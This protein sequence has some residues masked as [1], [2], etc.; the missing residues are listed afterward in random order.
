MTPPREYQGHPD[1]GA[2]PQNGPDRPD[3]SYQDRPWRAIYLRL[4]EAA[5]DTVLDHAR[6]YNLRD[7]SEFF[8]ASLRRLA[9]ELTIYDPDLF[10]RELGSY[11]AGR[12]MGLDARGFYQN[13]PRPIGRAKVTLDPAPLGPKTVFQPASYRKEAREIV[14]GIRDSALDEA[15]VQARLKIKA[16][17]SAGRLRYLVREMIQTVEELHALGFGII[18]KGWAQGAVPVVTLD[19]WNGLTS[20]AQE[21][22]VRIQQNT[23]EEV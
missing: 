7:P 11:D 19:L 23:P 21:I 10:M 1:Q 22:S 5:L 12:P 15:T 8:G 13:A 20:P 18:L 6:R 4:Q 3:N 9:R 14:K 16:K 2:D 17:S